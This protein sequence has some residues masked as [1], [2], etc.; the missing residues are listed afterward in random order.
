MCYTGSVDEKEPPTEDVGFQVKC[1]VL[2]GP[3][4]V[5]AEAEIV[6]FEQDGF[7]LAETVKGITKR[8]FYPYERK[9]RHL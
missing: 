8:M 7:W 2:W 6:G 3:T 9:R 4:T 1:L 5:D